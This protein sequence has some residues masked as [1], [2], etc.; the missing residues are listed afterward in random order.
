MG[1]CRSEEEGSFI[2]QG[3][4]SHSQAFTNTAGQRQSQGRGGGSLTAVLCL[5]TE[6]WRERVSRLKHPA[7]VMSSWNGSFYQRWICK[8][9]QTFM[10]S[11]KNR[12]VDFKTAV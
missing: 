7:A 9:C 10:L 1:C 12:F 6:K 4:I 11:D 8:V 2:T 5:Q 3:H